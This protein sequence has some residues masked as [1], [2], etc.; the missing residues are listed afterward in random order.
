MKKNYMEPSVVVAEVKLEGMTCA[1]TG[2]V[3]SDYGI[4][5]GG[6]DEQGTKEPSARR[7]DVWEDDGE[8]IGAE[9]F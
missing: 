1:S 4:D 5:Y 9:V 2:G 8:D 7:R 6:V 3:S